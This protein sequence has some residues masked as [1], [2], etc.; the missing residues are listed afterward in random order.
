MRGNSGSH[1]ADSTELSRFMKDL[2]VFLLKKARRGLPGNCVRLSSRPGRIEAR[3][4][5][6]P[7]HE[8]KDT[9]LVFAATLWQTSDSP[10]CCRL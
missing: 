8:V 10:S 5:S 9:S 7:G 6:R 1:A 2:I 3:G 4:D